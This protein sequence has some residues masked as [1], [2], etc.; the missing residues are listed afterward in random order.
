V[1]KH[2]KPQWFRSSHFTRLALIEYAKQVTP[3]A[4]ID[5]EELIRFG[6]FFDEQSNGEQP[7]I[8]HV[9]KIV[10]LYLKQ[11]GSV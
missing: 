2:S 5:M 11:K 10:D 8:I 1:K 4:G 7:T 6:M 3:P 9:E